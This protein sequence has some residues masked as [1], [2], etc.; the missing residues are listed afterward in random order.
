MSAALKNAPPAAT[1]GAPIIRVRDLVKEFNVTR[2]RGG[3]P[4]SGGDLRL[5]A[6]RGAHPGS[7]GQPGAGAA[8]GGGRR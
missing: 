6:D 7:G 4:A 5:A 3:P 8:A 1:T 2:G